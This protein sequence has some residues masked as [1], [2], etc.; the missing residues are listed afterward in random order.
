MQEVGS[1]INNY[2][3]DDDVD[4]GDVDDNDNCDNCDDAL[5]GSMEVQ[6]IFI[7]K[8]TIF[9]GGA[10]LIVMMLQVVRCGLSRPDEAHMLGTENSA[11]MYGR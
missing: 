6:E 7:K 11:E 10:S 2:G 8:Q 5:G 1:N 4:K 9:L 3:N